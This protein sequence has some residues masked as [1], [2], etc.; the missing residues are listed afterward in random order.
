MSFVKSAV[1]SNCHDLWCFPSSDTKPHTNLLQRKV[2]VFLFDY[3]KDK[4]F[5][6]HHPMFYFV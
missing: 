2:D 1:A 6:S 5:C 4:T 3:P